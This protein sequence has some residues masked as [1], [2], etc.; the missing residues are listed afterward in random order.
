[1][2]GEWPRRRGWKAQEGDKVEER[3]VSWSERPS[4]ASV[5]NPGGKSMD[6]GCSC[7][8]ED[9][10]SSI[11]PHVTPLT[12]GGGAVTGAQGGVWDQ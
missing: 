9:G 8:Q 12:T 11:S 1:M 3:R 7:R 10:D 4:L 6:E 2:R 5:D